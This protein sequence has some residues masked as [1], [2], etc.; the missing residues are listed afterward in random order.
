M[1][2]PKGKPKSEASKAKARKAMLE[3][4]KAHPE[5]I[6]A[7]TTRLRENQSKIQLARKAYLDSYRRK[8]QTCPRCKKSFVRN[9]TPQK[10]CSVSCARL[11]NGGRVIT[12]QGYVKVWTREDYLNSI[13]RKPKLCIRCNKDY[14]PKSAKQKFCS[15]SCGGRTKNGRIINGEGYVK[16]A[17]G[18]KT[19]SRYVL[20]HRIVMEK[21]LGRPLTSVETVHHKNGNRQDN[22]PENLELWK[23]RQPKGQRDTEQGHCPTCTCT[24]TRS[25]G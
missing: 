13:R 14:V 25:S 22:R 16:V 21:I 20:E 17:T 23:S 4:Y 9:Q 18:D 5:A 7:H 10:Y 12:D 6:E 8:P 3:H 11:R 1:P 15:I 2:Y 24:D 19:G